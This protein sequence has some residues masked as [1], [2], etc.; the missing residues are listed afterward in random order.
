MT[1]DPRLVEIDDRMRALGRPAPPVVDWLASGAK[2]DFV[3]RTAAWK[4][5]VAS[6]EAS[7]PEAA[8]EWLQLR[9]TYRAEEEVLDSRRFGDDEWKYEN[10]RRL[11]CPQS[12][13]DAI[14]RPLDE[15]Q[16][17]RAAREW[18]IGG[19]WAL[20][21]CGPPGC[22]KT[23]AAAWAAHQ[24]YMRLNQRP[25]W[26]RCAAMVDAPAFNAEAELLKYRCKEAGVLILDDIGAGAREKDAKVW[27]GWL[28]DVLDHRWGNKRKTIITSNMGTGALAS[29][30]G[31]RLAD[32]LNEGVI[33]GSTDKSMRGGP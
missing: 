32:R 5:R 23:T 8:V 33:H 14:R 4:A 13:L 21:L 29:W 12:A 2:G 17:L 7:K 20:V 3:A 9:E 1:Y 11:G 18:A 27:M 22:G 10:M 26:L 19:T 31:V 16:S 30:L 28:D 25:K 24:L 6:W 15:K